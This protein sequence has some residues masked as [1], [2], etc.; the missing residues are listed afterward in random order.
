MQPRR[1]FLAIA[2]GVAVA[3][4]YFA[5]PLLV[6]MGADLGIAAGTVGAFVTVTQIGYGL[7][8]FFLVPLGD[9]I[10]RRRL[11][12]LQ[13][14][15]LAGALIV[16]GVARNAAMLLLGLAAVGLLAVVTQSLVAFAASLSSPA[17]RG[18]TVG[19]VTS[20]IVIGIL[21][22][23]TSSG[24]LTDL[25]AWR[26]VYLISGVL[27]LAI[28]L[29]IFQAGPQPKAQLS[30]Y[31]LLRSTV[32]LWSE[33]PVFRAHAVL[34][35]FVFAAFSTLW[36]SVVLPLTEL[37]LSHTEIG[38]FG[39][40][41]AAGALAAGPAG[42]LNDRGRGRLVF[43]GASMLLAMSWLLIVW[44]PQSLWALA[45]GA[46]ALDLA[47]QAVHVSNQSRIYELRP[48]AGS[49]LIGGYMVFYSIGSG[50]GAIASTALYS[51]AGWVGVCVLGSAF[52]LGAVATSVRAGRVT[53]PASRPCE[54]SR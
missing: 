49:R 21:L 20:G 44:T 46:I 16:V 8:L 28:A 2:A 50:L 18:R 52:S 12:R 15:L 27:C 22:A 1:L 41:G 23:R 34:A 33:E 29:T 35:F 42:R 13:F 9:L 40:I 54:S 5:Q 4:V 6:T 45:I 31:G 17:E 25:V 47:V 14:V 19:A 37:G 26:S 7:S 53:S 24:L 30:Y 39:L 51:R 43:V 11:I 32:N 36:S 48:E 10:D 38:L 3:N